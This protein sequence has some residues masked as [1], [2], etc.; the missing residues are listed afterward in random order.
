MKKSTAMVRWDRP[1]CI[2]TSHRT[3]AMAGHF[4]HAIPVNGDSDHESFFFRFPSQRWVTHDRGRKSPA[5]PNLSAS[6]RLHAFK[7]PASASLLPGLKLV[8]MPYVGCPQL[9]NAPV[10]L[11]LHLRLPQKTQAQLATSDV[12]RDRGLKGVRILHLQVG[13]SSVCQQQQKSQC[14]SST[15]LPSF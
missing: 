10:F 14:W 2:E 12:V 1:L 7:Q 5:S 6:G 4:Q 9:S 3:S 13:G 11:T 8:P 15:C